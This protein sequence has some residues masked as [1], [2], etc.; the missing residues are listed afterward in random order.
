TELT[1]LGHQVSIM[2]YTHFGGGQLIYKL[3]DGFLGASDPRK[4]GQAVGF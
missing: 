1:Q 2:D 4:D 3:E